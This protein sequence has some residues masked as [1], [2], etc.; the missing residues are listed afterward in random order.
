[1][2]EEHSISAMPPNILILRRKTVRQ[3]PNHTMVALYYN[4]KLDQYFSIPY[5]GDIET[6][7]TGMGLKEETEQIDEVSDK[8]ANAAFYA[9]LGRSKFASKKGDRKEADRNLTKAMQTHERIKKKHLEEETEQIDELSKKTLGNYA[10][11][12]VAALSF[13]A[14][15]HGVYGERTMGT[16]TPKDMKVMDDK[17]KKAAITAT[18]RELGLTNAIN[19]LRKE[20]TEQIDEISH[21]VAVK[22]FDARLSRGRFA[23]KKG[24]LEAARMNLDKAKATQRRINTKFEKNGKLLEEP[25]PINE[26]SKTTLSNY[27]KKSAEEVRDLSHQYGAHLAQA[28]EYGNQDAPYHYRI[29]G[30]RNKDVKQRMSGLTTAIGKLAKEDVEEV[31]ESVYRSSPRA[32]HFFKGMQRNR[33]AEWMASFE[34][35]VTTHAPEH[36]GKIQWDDAQYHYNQEHTPEDAAKKYVESHKSGPHSLHMTEAIEKNPIDT[37]RDIRDEHTMN[38]VRHADGTSTMVEHAMAHALLSVHDALRPELR[39]KFAEQ[40][41]KSQ[42]SLEKMVDFAR[43]NVG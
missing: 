6:L 32:E 15:R 26:L 42:T 2:L 14:Y 34:K 8:V 33:K 27:A 9:R 4:D 25:E 40:I 18:H 28:N 19:R 7:N 22:A 38:T 35:H 31:Q 43:K 1:M 30:R 10:H 5:G 21:K 3:F 24:D 13:D 23:T 16:K 37:L 17:A 39:T 12:A 41:G 36:T 20:E 11:K 29:A